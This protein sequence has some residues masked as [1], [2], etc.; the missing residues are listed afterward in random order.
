MLDT[1]VF[2]PSEVSVVPLRVIEA[3]RPLLLYENS[4]SAQPVSV[5]Y[6]HEPEL[7]DR[8][9]LR[10]ILVTFPGNDELS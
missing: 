2:V 7:V 10:A 1:V 9:L 5:P 4:V 3:S 6:A 8:S